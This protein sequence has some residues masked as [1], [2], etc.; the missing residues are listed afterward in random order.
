MNSLDIGENRSQRTF[1]KLKEKLKK[2]KPFVQDY[3]G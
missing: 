2:R 1:T 3:D